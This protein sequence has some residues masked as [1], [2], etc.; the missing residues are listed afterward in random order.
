MGHDIIEIS[1]DS[2]SE[3]DLEAEEMKQKFQSLLTRNLKKQTL[4][5]PTNNPPSKRQLIEAEVIELLDSDDDDVT[6]PT[7]KTETLISTIPISSKYREQDIKTKQAL[8]LSLKSSS[9]RSRMN[10]SH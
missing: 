8:F 4:S 9:L 2:E 6:V 5:A 7:I 3:P 1:S 10:S